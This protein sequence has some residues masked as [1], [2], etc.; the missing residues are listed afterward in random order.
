M[1]NTNT[2]K[3]LDVTDCAM[4]CSDGLFEPFISNPP[5]LL[6]KRRKY[7]IDIETGDIYYTDGTFL[8]PPAQEL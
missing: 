6:G 5:I 8:D 1:T 4:L 3:H 2:I 7:A